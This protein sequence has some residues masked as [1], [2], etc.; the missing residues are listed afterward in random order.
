M[1]K[2]KIALLSKIIIDKEIVGDKS[3]NLGESLVA[4]GRSKERSSSSSKYG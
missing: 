1:S 4:R 2:G 3:D